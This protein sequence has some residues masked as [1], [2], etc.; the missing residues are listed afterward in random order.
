MKM[1]FEKPEEKND[2]YVV[3][4]FNNARIVHNPKDSERVTWEGA[5]LVAKNP[6]L[7]KVAGFS[8]QYWKLKDG[9][10]VPLSYLERVAR[11]EHIVANGAINE[12][13]P[14]IEQSMVKKSKAFA[15]VYWAKALAGA[16]IAGLSMLITML[17]N[18]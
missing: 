13:M 8:P 15:R 10:V 6:D 9:E 2:F 12:F 18:H 7:S 5:H 4:T 17:I 11:S 3:F 16:F 14:Y 1:W